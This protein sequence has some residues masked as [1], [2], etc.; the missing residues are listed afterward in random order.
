MFKR[1]Y[2]EITNVC[3]LRCDFC[4][5][6]SRPKGFMAAEDFRHLAAKLR[7]YGDYLYLHVMG[8]PLLHPALGEI[9]DAADAQ[10]FRVCLTTNGTLLPERA[11]TLLSAPALHK[12]SVSLHSFEANGGGE[13]AGYL[14][15]VMDFCGRAAAQ[16]ILCALRLWNEGG[17]NRLNG[18]VETYLSRRLGID[19]PSLTRDRRGN[20]TLGENLF[21]E[22]GERF[23][24]PDPA[25]PERKATFCHA[26]REQLA[27]LWDGT[28]VPCCLDAEGRMALGN[29]FTQDLDEILSSPRA[30]AMRRGFGARRPGE[31]LCRR[32]GY[33]ERFNR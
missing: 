2:L 15:G 1:L 13:I 22:P 10:G 30:E 32:C 21:L 28:V 18:A 9:L 14:G 12:V 23:D 33:A 24:W 3:N 19:V 29:L 26:L 11:A 25:A 6:T 27:V 7:P 16:G 17:E 4:P 31:E 20:R 5:G 8:E